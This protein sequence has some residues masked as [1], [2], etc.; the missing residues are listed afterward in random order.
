MKSKYIWPLKLQFIVFDDSNTESIIHIYIY[1]YIYIIYIY[2]SKNDNKK[3]S[4]L[5]HIVVYLCNFVNFRKTAAYIFILHFYK[6]T[7][8]FKIYSINESQKHEMSKIPTYCLNLK[9][10]TA[11][12]TCIITIVYNSRIRWIYNLGEKREFVTIFLCIKKR[13]MIL[14][15]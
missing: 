5:H 15:I 13:F 8:T 3:F 7:F 12:N 9:N 14:Y 10:I 1:I 2:D 4:R 11:D 6:K